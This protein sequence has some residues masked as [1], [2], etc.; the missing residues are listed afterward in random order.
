MNLATIWWTITERINT[1]IIWN[2]ADFTWRSF[3][4]ATIVFWIIVGYLI[5]FLIIVP[6]HKLYKRRKIKL[7]KHI[8]EEIDWMIYVL[9]KTQHKKNIDLEALWGNPNIALMKSIFTK[10]NCNYIESIFLILDNMHKVE[11]ILREEVLPK[12]NEIKLLK[13]EKKYHRIC[14]IE[15]TLKGIVAVATLWIYLLFA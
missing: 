9:A 7:E 15:A 1:N 13:N 11:N 14:F 2:I 12:E 6:L 8:T 4:T 3:Q 5:I 10:G